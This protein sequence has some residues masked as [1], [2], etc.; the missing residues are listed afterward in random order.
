MINVT[1]K[2]VDKTKTCVLFS[3]TSSK[4]R[5]V[6]QIIWKN[7]LERGNPQMA[8]YNTALTFC[9]LYYKRLH[10]HTHTHT[11]T[12][13]NMQLIASHGNNGHANAPQCYVVRT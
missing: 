4:N 12:L 3:I 11:H 7:M 1:D 10:T 5:A 8:Q 2:F 13:R 6:Y 9:V